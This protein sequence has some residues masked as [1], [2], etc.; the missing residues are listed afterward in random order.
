MLQERPYSDFAE[1]NKAIRRNLDSLLTIRECRDVLRVSSN[2]I[3]RLIR[4]GDLDA[5]DVVGNRLDSSWIDTKTNGI[6][7][8]PES[9]KRFL[10]GNRI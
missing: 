10:D 8:S 7:I 3:I 1:R 9:L 6:R 4:Q 5:Y 2:H